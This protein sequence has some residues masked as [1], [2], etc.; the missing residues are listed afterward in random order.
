[1]PGARLPGAVP[2]G[3]RIRIRSRIR[4]PPTP[5]AKSIKPIKP[6]QHAAAT[7]GAVLGLV[8]LLGFLPGL[9]VHIEDLTVAGHHTTTLLFG[10][11]EVSVL[12]NA[13]HL[14][15][16]VAGLAM[17]TRVRTARW[18]LLAGGAAYLLLAALGLT[19]AADVIALNTPDIWLNLVFGA[20]MLGLGFLPG[21]RGQ[22]IRAA[23]KV[24]SSS[25]S[26]RFPRRT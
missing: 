3:R 10:V 25:T 13:I 1:M 4:L 2:A 26:S 7:A 14:L 5:P 21:R 24:I 17:A 9:T 18:F 12:H 19:A 20:V 15:F 16:A 11:F 23:S 8:G 22:A 6:V